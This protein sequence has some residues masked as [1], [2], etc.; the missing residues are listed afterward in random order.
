LANKQYIS[1][2]RLFQHCD[3]EP[4]M[5]FNLSRAK[6][7]LQAEF[8]VAQQGFIEIDG[9]TYTRHDVFEEIE[10]PDFDKRLGFHQMIWRRPQILLL[11]EKNAANLQAIEIEFKPFWS[12]PEFD[13]F[14]SPYFAGPFAY[15]SR[16]LISDLNL[17]ELGFLLAYEDFL[18]PEEREEA[19]KPI[20]LFLDET[21]R[22]LRNVNK[23]NYNIMRPKIAHWIDK[24]WYMFFNNLPHEF[25]DIK[26]DITTRLVNIGVAVQKKRRRD[27]QAMSE[28][29]ISLQD[30]PET[31]RQ[32]IV[33]NHAVYTGSGS[34]GG[35]SSWK[36]AWWVIWIIIMLIRAASS[37][38]CNSS[39]SYRDNNDY[40]RM[41]QYKVADS[42]FQKY[43]DANKKKGS[44]SLT[45]V[46]I[47][48]ERN[49][50]KPDSMIR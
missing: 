28:Q 50:E 31:L 30:T 11:L 26:F 40:L 36:S 48:E 46:K 9:Y 10:R 15:I 19:F 45:G 39:N 6:K 8:S 20:R 23:E 1:I 49:V 4:G 18:Q 35:G 7:Q 41:E 13:K 32:T 47:I 34:S 38:G 24:D 12:N 17:R 27:C 2:I 25:Y 5:E 21:L 43:I 14:F 42:I 33:S 22:V 16:T 29:L 44:D 3:I 37:D